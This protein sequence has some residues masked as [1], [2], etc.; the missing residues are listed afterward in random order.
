M[1]ITKAQIL[2]LNEVIT[3]LN[4]CEDEDERRKYLDTAVEDTDLFLQALRNVNK[5]KIEGKGRKKSGL[6][7]N[8]MISHYQEEEVERIFEDGRV[9]EIAQQYTKA[10]LTE[11]YYTVYRSK[12]LSAANKERIAHSIRQHFYNIDR[13]KALLG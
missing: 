10:Q 4:S 13:T 6:Q 8:T 12:P 2:E 1:C 9:E 3:N 7:S 11:M 5:K